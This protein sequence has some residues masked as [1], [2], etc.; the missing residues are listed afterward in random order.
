M[1]F[2]S[3]V[4]CIYRGL[5]FSWA[6]LFLQCTEVAFR[7]GTGPH[8]RYEA[9]PNKPCKVST[10][11]RRIHLEYRQRIRRIVVDE[12]QIKEWV[13]QVKV[14][15][16]MPL[17]SLSHTGMTWSLTYIS[18]F[19]LCVRYI[20]LLFHEMNHERL[21]AWRPVPL[22]CLN[23]EDIEGYLAPPYRFQNFIFPALMSREI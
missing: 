9:I 4:C 14:Y 10:V 7:S 3:I 5:G 19:L 21:V 2:K 23:A 8:G 6:F 15:S 22:L 12:E 11:C 16:T 20:A 13:L 17:F 1:K 18:A